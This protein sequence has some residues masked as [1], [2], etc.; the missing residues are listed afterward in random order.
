[1][2]GSNEDRG[3]KST[4]WSYVASDIVETALFTLRMG[5][6]LSTFTFVICS[7][8]IYGHFMYTAYLNGMMSAVLTFTLR[9][10]QRKKE[11]QV[12]LLSKEM[13]VMLATEDSAHYMLYTFFF[14][15]QFPTSIY[16]LPPL[17]YA[18]IFTHKYTDGMKRYLP[19]TLQSLLQRLNERLRNGQRDVF[20]FIAYT[21]IFIFLVV[22]WNV[23]IGH[24]FFLAPLLYYF[25]LKSRYLSKRNHYIKICF[26][27]LR[28][29]ADQLSASPR[30][31]SFISSLIAGLVSFISQLAPI[32]QIPQQA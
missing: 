15:N 14:Y 24:M 21:E 22:L 20:R 10:Y 5:T 3:R 17:L 18:I 31:P 25:F 26:S 13:Y 7:L 28:F 16:L 9:L 12:S 27:E 30:C 23:I 1:M 2:S 19:P 4:L 8:G 6:I 29:A 11:Q 32:Q